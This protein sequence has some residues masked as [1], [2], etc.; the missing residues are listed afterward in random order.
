[1]LC[2]TTISYP[3]CPYFIAS[4]DFSRSSKHELKRLYLHFYTRKNY[5]K[6][7]LINLH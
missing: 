6:L 2:S 7:I 1:M 4:F 5:E 3:L